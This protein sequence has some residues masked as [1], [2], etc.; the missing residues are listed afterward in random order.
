MTK[1][2]LTQIDGKLPNLALM[3]LAAYWRQRKAD[4]H[5]TKGKQQLDIFH[6]DYDHV[7]ASA[8]F[9][10]SDKL[11]ADFRFHF[12]NAIVGGT[13]TTSALT[14]EQTLPGIEAVKPDYRDYPDFDGSLGFTQR[15]CRLKCGFC[16]V[17]KKE[18]S[19]HGV[20]SVYDIWRGAPWPRHLH[21][22]DNDFFGQDGWQERVAEI[23]HGK[24]KVC[25]NQGI[26]VRMIDDTS[27]AALASMD[28]RDD[29]FIKQRIYTAWDNIGDERRFFDGI[30][31][32]QRHGIPPSHVMAYMLVGYD[33][34]ETW[35]RLFYRYDRMCA[36]GI[37]PYV[38]IFEPKRRRGLP[39]GT[40]LYEPI[41]Q[42]G[43][44]LSHFQRWVNRRYYT[45]VTEFAKFDPAWTRPGP[46]SKDAFW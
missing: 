18:G 35:E 8:I 1:V 39:A 43:L 26:N 33:R 3:R 25:L 23:R 12:P 7:Y 36:L 22:L 6:R 9:A 10:F 34:R 32:L 29:S 5:L 41:T 14:L 28:Y 46:P 20:A 30:A 19:N 16:V 24:F 11:L 37:K 21:L 15:G 40:G 2:R 17:P 13:G 27:A 45:V 31:C 44:T 42:R 38:M 4:V